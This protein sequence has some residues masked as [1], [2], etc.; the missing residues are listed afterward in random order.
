LFLQFPALSINFPATGTGKPFAPPAFT[1]ETDSLQLPQQGRGDSLPQALLGVK[2]L[3]P[4]VLR[5]NACA[6]F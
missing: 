2:L 6:T 5:R 4:L 1:P 3:T